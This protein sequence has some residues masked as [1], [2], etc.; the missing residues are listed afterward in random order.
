MEILPGR[1]L[2][3]LA[4]GSK[5]LQSQSYLCC[6][7]WCRKALGKKKKKIKKDLPARD[8]QA[9]N[10]LQFLPVIAAAVRPLC[11]GFP[12]PEGSPCPSPGAA[13]PAPAAPPRSARPGAS[14]LRRPAL[15]P[16]RSRFLPSARAA[17]N[18]SAGSV[19]AS[20]FLSA[21]TDAGWLQ[22]L[23]VLPPKW[24]LQSSARLL[25]ATYWVTVEYT[26][27]CKSVCTQAVIFWLSRQR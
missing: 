26:Y 3:L 10:A 1:E 25:T 2:C 9:P 27:V 12:P 13:A 23:L 5:D 4:K 17:A 18:A 6:T 22:P 24:R 16:L 14:P 11:P 21:F 19:A 7:R 15:L 20:P 8:Q